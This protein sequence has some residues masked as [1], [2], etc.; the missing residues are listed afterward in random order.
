MD[1]QRRHRPGSPA[2]ALYCIDALSYIDP[3]V[4]NFLFSF[5][6]LVYIGFGG[7]ASIAGSVLGPA[8]L[9]AFGES[10][11]F[12]GLPDLEVTG[13]VQSKRSSRCY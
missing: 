5:N 13:P 2:G 7:L 12:G 10:L 6:V 3:T 1:D 11:R 9:I 8:I 4:F